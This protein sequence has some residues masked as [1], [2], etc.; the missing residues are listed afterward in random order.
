MKLGVRIG[1][2]RVE[3]LNMRS[4]TFGVA[5]NPCFLHATAKC[6]ALL[7]SNK[8]GWMSSAPPSTVI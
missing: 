2:E 7:A 3:S 4:S 5:T 6:G 8:S 1:A